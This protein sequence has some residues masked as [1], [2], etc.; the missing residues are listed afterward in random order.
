MPQ[1]IDE[2]ISILAKYGNKAKI[3]AGGTDLLVKMR[4]RV[5]TPGCVVSVNKIKGLNAIDG[6]PKGELRIGAATTMRSIES[7][8]VVQDYYTVL[9]EAVCQIGTAQV[10][11]MATIGGNLCNASPA[12]DTAPPL[13][14]LGAEIKIVSAPG[15]RETT[16]LIPIEGFFAGPGK[17]ILQSDEMLT[18][19]RLKPIAKG[20][21][22]AFLKIGRLGV[23]ISKVSAAACIRIVDGVCKVARISLGA[24]APTPI[25]AKKA[26]ITLEGKKICE[27][28]VAE[29]GDAGAEEI[30]P[31]KDMRSTADYR[32]EVSKVIVRRVIIRACQ[33]AGVDV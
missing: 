3:L 27:D 13:I 31:V 9:H 20:T 1:T 23:D 24:V 16:R 22:C 32:R 12:A 26:E 29:A 10:R 8:R 21:G 2:A 25:R 7:S 11:N 30:R 19:I 15:N 17:T 6:D 28:I 5:L 18:E 4:Q 14:S 33:R